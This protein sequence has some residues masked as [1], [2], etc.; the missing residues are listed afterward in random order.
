MGRTQSK[1]ALS[2]GQN[3]TRDASGY[4]EAIYRVSPQNRNYLKW[5][6]DDLDGG[7]GDDVNGIDRFQLT[8][9]KAA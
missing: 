9:E 3:G 5:E 7:A 4:Y 2:T 1:W 8:L 6:Y